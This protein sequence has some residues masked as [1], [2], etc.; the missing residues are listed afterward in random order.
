[1][2]VGKI[3]SQISGGHIIGGVKLSTECIKT[4]KLLITFPN[5]FPI[6]YLPFTLAGIHLQRQFQFDANEWLIN[7][8]IYRLVDTVV[9]RPKEVNGRRYTIFD[10]RLGG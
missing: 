5:H 2:E 8:E 7:E 10:G 1:M 4:V 3:S 6:R 9:N